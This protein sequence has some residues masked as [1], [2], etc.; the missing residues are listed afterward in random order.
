MREEDPTAQYAQMLHVEQQNHLSLHI[1][2]A[3]SD[4][5]AQG[6]KVNG[7]AVQDELKV[8]EAA[9]R[10]LGVVTANQRMSEDLVTGTLRWR[11]MPGKV[12]CQRNRPGWF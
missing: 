4:L 2:P 7:M 1:I 6:I 9:A 5:Y 8:L 10:S 11:G 12:Y 3:E